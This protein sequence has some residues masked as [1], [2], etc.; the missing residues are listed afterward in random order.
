[1]SRDYGFCQTSGSARTSPQTKNYPTPKSKSAEVENL[2]WTLLRWQ[3]LRYI[4]SP[5]SYRV[6][7]CCLVAKSCPTLCDSM[8]CSPPGSS[9]HGI[10]Q[11]RILEWV[12]IP[13]SRGSSWPRDWT[14]VSCIGTQILYHWAIWEAP[15]ELSEISKLERPCRPTLLPGEAIWA[16]HLSIFLLWAENSTEGVGGS[17][18]IH[19][20]S[21]YQAFRKITFLLQKKLHELH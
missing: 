15:T 3:F 12:A 1:M 10:L 6:I 19:Q 11:A 21:F 2:G 20:F 9:L 16:E 13:F 5:L 7:C 8:D 17:K 14:R 18:K 4:W